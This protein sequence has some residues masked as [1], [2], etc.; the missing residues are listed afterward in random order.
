MSSEK[1]TRISCLRPN[2]VRLYTI[3]SI[4][5]T[6]HELD[7]KCDSK[8]VAKYEWNALFKDNAFHLKDSTVMIL[9]KK[10]VDF[11]HFLA[12]LHKW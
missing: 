5:V 4:N 7:S 3:W 9:S 8:N 12:A 2:N 1:N 6:I 10:Q 11:K